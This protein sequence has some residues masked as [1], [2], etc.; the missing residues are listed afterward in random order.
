MVLNEHK[1]LIFSAKWNDK[2]NYLLTAGIDQVLYECEIGMC[3]IPLYR[4]PVL[5]G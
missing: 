4:I 5:T 3:R 2:G 1:G